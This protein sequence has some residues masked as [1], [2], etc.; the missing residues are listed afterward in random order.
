VVF[1]L[2]VLAAGCG[3]AG[4][5]TL[6]GFAVVVV[7]DVVVVAV[8]FGAVEDDGVAGLVAGG[9]I[10]VTGS[11]GF[12]IGLDLT[13]AINSLRPASEPLLRYL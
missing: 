5:V 4:V 2:E 9:V 11:P 6:F 8:P 12:G 1:V 7:V 10:G 3:V 13:A